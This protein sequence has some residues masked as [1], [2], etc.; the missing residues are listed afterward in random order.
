M[1]GDNLLIRAGRVIDP[2]S[3][4]DDTLDVLIQ[5]GKIAQLGKSL[6]PPEGTPVYEADGLVVAPGF[7]DSHVH[8]REPGFEHKETIATGAASA[9]AGGICSV[10]TMPNTDPPPDRPERLADTLRRAASAQIRIYPIAAVTLNKIP[11]VATVIREG[12]RARLRHEADAVGGGA[13]LR[14]GLDLRL[15]GHEARGVRGLDS[16]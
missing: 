9:V 6:S 15:D 2:G 11:N 7:I 1:I 14:T 4:L 12:A 10:A 13:G 8:L 16:R 5:E 3:G